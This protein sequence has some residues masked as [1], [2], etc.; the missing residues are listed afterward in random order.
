MHY[1]A[2]RFILAVLLFC[3]LASTTL[4]AQVF[5]LRDT[6]CNNQ[7]IVVNNHL[8][9][10]GNPSGT[11]VLPGAASNGTDS[12]VE[13]RLV[14]FQPV[15]LRLDQT[16]CEG[17]TVWV[18]QIPYHAGFTLGTEIIEGGAANGCDSIIDV[19]LRFLETVTYKIEQVICEGDTLLVNGVA[20]DAYHTTGTEVVTGGAPNGQCDSIIQVRLTPA[21]L[22]YS[23]RTD[24]LCPDTFLMINGRR[25]DRNNRYGLEILP[26]AA[27]NGCDSLVNVRLTF[28]ELWLS[29]GDDL[30]IAL[31][32]SACIT[33]LF[34]MQPVD[35]YWSPPLPCTSIDCLPYCKSFFANEQYTLDA[36]DISGC[37]LRD[38]IRIAV[39]KEPP[40]Y[41]PTAFQPGAEWPN[42]Y[43][44]LSAGAG[45]AGI[46]HLQIANR[47]GEVVFDKSGTAPNTPSEGWDGNWRGKTAPPGVY[48]F[49]ANLEWIDGSTQVISG[50]F[51]LVH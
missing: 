27:A 5:F 45:I 12:I 9:G 47:W 33:P 21:P 10:P 2:F 4:N 44:F 32:D 43:F 23:E 22:P 1:R 48:I 49:W 38:D 26:N 16:L 31:G 11:E 51:A 36:T 6:F 8:Y 37:V 24:T 19:N 7:L 35:L 20:Y 42:N 3:G 29:L 30:D 34:G 15:M 40:V 50:S 13:V 17:D 28:R 46:K 39:R 25:Y 18:N 14:F 41:A